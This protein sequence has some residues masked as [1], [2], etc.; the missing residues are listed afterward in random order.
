MQI[1]G[2]PEA[3]YTIADVKIAPLQVVLQGPAKKLQDLKAARTQPIDING[4]SDILKKEIV[5]DLSENVT[6]I[7]PIDKLQAQVIIQAQLISK[8]FKD[9]AVVGKGTNLAYT[10]SPSLITLKVSGPAPLLEKLNAARDIEVAIDLSGLAAG[11]YARPA[12]ISLPVNTTLVDVKP[13][14]FTIK[15]DSSSK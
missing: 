4:V 9:I 12:S 6:L 1:V 8:V 2:Q 14:V 15:L 7:S 11:I 10:I 5:L 13:E 3:G